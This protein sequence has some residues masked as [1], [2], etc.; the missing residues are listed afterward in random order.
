MNAAILLRLTVV[1]LLAGGALACTAA[2]ASPRRELRV[3]AD[4]NNLPFSNQS[5]EGFENKLAELLARELDATVRYT[6]WA[7][8]R[9]FVRNTLRAN[10]CDV[11]MGMPSSMELAL[12]TR[13][14]YRSTYVFLYRED[15]GLSIRSIDDSVL[16]TV[17]IGV[18]V[19]GDDYANTPAAHSLG[20]RGI[21]DNV[22]GY[23]IYGDYAQPNP[24]ARLVEAVATG[25]VDVAIVWGPLAGYFAP[26]QS[27]PLTMVPV[28]PQVDLP[29]LPYV[30]DISLGVR[31]GED[32]LRLE[33]EAALERA[34]P[35]LAALLEEYGVPL[36]MGGGTRRP[37]RPP[38]DTGVVR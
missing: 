33:L 22:R 29:F 20:Q 28:S 23:T 18:H 31:R 26:R 10:L 32:S 5:E 25:E 24:P 19:I 12:P 13:P 34:E 36:V 35:E 6:W 21:V 14:Y 30:F 38:A 9:G 15:S 1:G 7:Q 11:I 16:R 8:R 4:P 17:R 27:V 3:C 2:D 37:R